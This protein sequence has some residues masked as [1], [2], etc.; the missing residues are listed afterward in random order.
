MRPLLQTATACTDDWAFHLHR[1]T[2]L[3]HLL[4]QGVL[5]SRWAP[6]MA[7]GY[8][9]PFFNFYAPLSYYLAWPLTLPFGLF[10]GLKLAFLFSIIGA[11]WALYPLARHYLPPR[12]A[13]IAALAYVYAPYLAYDVYWRGNWA[14]SAAWFIL[15]LALLTLLRYQLNP[16]ARTL[17]LSATTYAAVL[18]THNAFAVIFSPLLL[19][20]ALL[21]DTLHSPFSRKVK[22]GQNLLPITLGLLFSAFFWLPAM[23]EKELVHSDRLLVPPIFVY[24]GNFI[25]L[26]ELLARPMLAQ[27]NLINPSP[28][29]ALGLLPILLAL[30]AY[31]RPTRTKL[32]WGMALLTYSLLML[33]IS[34][35]LWA[36]LPLLEYVQFPWRMLGPAALC[37]A[38]LV[39]FSFDSLHTHAKRQGQLLLFALYSAILVGNA[40]GWLSPRYCPTDTKPT[41]ET[42]VAYEL[43]TG[44]LGTTA[45]GEY[46]PRSADYLPDT[47]RAN[48]LTGAT[49]VTER[50]NALS[51]HFTLQLSQPTTITFQQLYFNGWQAQLNGKPLPITP[52]HPHGLITFDLPAGQHQ[53]TIWFGATPLR[54]VI[55]L[56]SAFAFILTLLIALRSSSRHRQDITP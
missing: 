24:W 39:G 22:Y 19:A 29:H 4:R 21:T 3:D 47:P 14:E 12:P 28:W 25:N 17:L 38:L 27:P 1:L 52:S 5:Y 15:P 40:G 43:A 8:G 54:R 51:A 45:K 2:Q 18:L 20:T 55:S 9:W 35:P 44:T 36:H 46:L 34:T 37:L 49:P 10:W 13:F 56:I 50:V 23:L 48:W 41:L 16:N 31:L 7:L 53:L 30:P 32:F 42:L 6:D 26:S 11:G 33:P